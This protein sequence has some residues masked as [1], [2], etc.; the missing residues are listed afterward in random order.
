MSK[1]FVAISPIASDIQE[2]VMDSIWY[3]D[4]QIESEVLDY[5]ACA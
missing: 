2:A 5:V 4:I 1:N 3:A